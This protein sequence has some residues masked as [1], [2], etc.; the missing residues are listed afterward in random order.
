MALS[1]LVSELLTESL[2]SDIILFFIEN[3]SDILLFCIDLKSDI[4]LFSIGF[5]STLLFWSLFLGVFY[6]ALNLLMK[7]VK[8]D[9]NYTLIECL[10]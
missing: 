9:P 7:F 3:N 5:N 8:D 10:S 2:F 4:I 1:S 6:T